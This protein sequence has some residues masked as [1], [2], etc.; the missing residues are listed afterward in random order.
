[1][2]VH[3]HVHVQVIQNPYSPCLRVSTSQRHYRRRCAMCARVFE[4]H[5]VSARVPLI[6]TLGGAT[7]ASG[8]GRTCTRS[9]AAPGLAWSKGH[10]GD[11]LGDAGGVGGCGDEAGCDGDVCAVRRW[12]RTEVCQWGGECGLGNELLALVARGWVLAGVDA[13]LAR[14]T[15]KNVCVVFARV[16]SR[17]DVTPCV[18][19]MGG[20]HT[21]IRAVLTEGHGAVLR[22]LPWNGIKRL[23]Y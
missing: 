16:E 13:T 23:S 3:V 17:G 4:R 8:R 7:A 9:P 21:W 14:T 12:C 18:V 2:Q 19:R 20:F 22:S 15:R 5:T 10:E 11:G 1:V 6:W